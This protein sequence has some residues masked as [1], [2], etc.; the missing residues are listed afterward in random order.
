MCYVCVRNIRNIFSYASSW[1]SYEFVE[2]ERE[3]VCVTES[4]R[5]R[6]CCVCEI[7]DDVCF[8]ICH[9]EEKM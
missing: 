5:E 4:L 8:V 6:V 2:C 9:V 1:H 3:R 7:G